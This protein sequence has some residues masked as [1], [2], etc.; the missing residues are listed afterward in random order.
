[1][2]RGSARHRT[3]PTSHQR[4]AS[5]ARPTCADDTAA[6][7]ITKD[8]TTGCE[9]DNAK[10]KKSKSRGLERRPAVCLCA[11]SVCAP[12][13][14][15]HHSSARVHTH[16]QQASSAYCPGDATVCDLALI[17]PAGHALPLPPTSPHAAPHAA[18]L[19]VLL[20]LLCLFPEPLIH[21]PFSTCSPTRT[22]AIAPCPSSAPLFPLPLL[23]APSLPS[24]PSSFPAVAGPSSTRS[25]E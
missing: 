2:P 7:R 9:T 10:A 1:M 3:R 19:L 25:R 5:L 15:H 22:P 21:L 14:P 6:A 4:L 17:L 23:P 11:L 18:S 12:P 16:S 20:L 13:F 8:A 24:L